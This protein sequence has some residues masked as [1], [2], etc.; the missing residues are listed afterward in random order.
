[1]KQFLRIYNKDKKVIRMVNQSDKGFDLIILIDYKLKEFLEI[2]NYC[3]TNE[4]SLNI[5]WQMKFK[6]EN[7]VLYKN[8]VFSAPM[9]NFLKN[10]PC[11]KKITVTCDSA[12]FYT[13]SSM[14]KDRKVKFVNSTYQDMSSLTRLLKLTELNFK[15]K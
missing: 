2:I 7:F 8:C 1:M 12:S 3:E 9:D 5:L 6:P 15:S 4:D 14:N 13:D 10:E 11:G